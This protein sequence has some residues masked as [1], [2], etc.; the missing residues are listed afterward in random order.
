VSILPDDVIRSIQGRLAAKRG[1]R[2]E[3]RTLRILKADGWSASRTRSGPVDV[4]AAKAGF[5]LL[6]QVKSGNATVTVSEAKSLVKWAEDF[7]ADAEVWS[8]RG[9]RLEKRRIYAT[10]RPYPLK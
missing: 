1:E 5:V 8:F 3:T 6:V 10:R 2:A 4:I 9:R 7:D